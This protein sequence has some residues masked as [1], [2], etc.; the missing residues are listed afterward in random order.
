MLSCLSRY[1]YIHIHMYVIFK[2]PQS[3]IFYI[4]IYMAPN[5]FRLRERFFFLSSN[6]FLW[7]LCI[8]F[9]FYIFFYLFYRALLYEDRSPVDSHGTQMSKCK[10]LKIDDLYIYIYSFTGKFKNNVCLWQSDRYIDREKYT[11]KI[12]RFFSYQL[13]HPQYVLRQTDFINLFF[14]FF[15]S[16]LPIRIY[17][18]YRSSEQ[19]Y[20]RKTNKK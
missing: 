10:R 7:F 4:H 17:N 5:C 14:Y 20:L 15:L 11:T 3:E 19:E 13:D 6:H 1:T 18:I 16:L 12:K 8:F 2:V 9:F